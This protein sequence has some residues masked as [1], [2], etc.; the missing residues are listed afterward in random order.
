[1]FDLCVFCIA[2]C[3]VVVLVVSAVCVC[4]LTR[5][6]R[7]RFTSTASRKIS[8]TSSQCA[9][10]SSTSIKPWRMWRHRHRHRHRHD[11]IIIINCML[12]HIPWQL[13]RERLRTL[14]I[15][16]LVNNNCELQRLYTMYR[17]LFIYLLWSRT[18]STHI[19][20]KLDIWNSSIKHKITSPN[21]Q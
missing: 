15:V 2:C 13:S 9:T 7:G 11:V 4:V 8:S 17:L 16:H 1:M 3:L 19:H 18:Q 6:S 12:F 14:L 5:M 10:A 21:K 20:R